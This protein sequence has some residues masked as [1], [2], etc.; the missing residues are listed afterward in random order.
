MNKHKARN[1][2]KKQEKAALSEKK[3]ALCT[4]LHTAL[5]TA[6]DSGDLGRARDVRFMLAGIAVFEA[7]ALDKMT[8]E[9]S[10]HALGCSALVG[11]QLELL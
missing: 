2:V 7:Y 5:Q 9:T 4:Q 3:E 6:I 10:L 8:L 1:Q 11:E